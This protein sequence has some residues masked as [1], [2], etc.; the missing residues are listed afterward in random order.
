MDPTRK[1]IV[2]L[3]TDTFDIMDKKGVNSDKFIDDIKHMTDDEF[4]QMIKALIS[5]PKKH[6]YFEIEAFEN[7]PIFEDIEKAAEFLGEEFVKLYDYIAWPHM[8]EDGEE[9]FSTINK[10]FTG[11]INMRRVNTY[12]PAA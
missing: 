2:D 8:S 5:D 6:L 12:S 1:E 7:E 3:I 4:F 9:H 11:Y 10:I